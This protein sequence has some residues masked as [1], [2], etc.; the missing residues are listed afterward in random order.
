MG[1]KADCTFDV[2]LCTKSPL[3]V[4]GN[5]VLET[6]EACDGLML[7]GNDCKKLGFVGGKLGCKADC[8]LDSSACISAEACD[9]AIDDDK[10]GHI[11][12]SDLDCFG[13]MGCVSA[14]E[15]FCDD[16]LDNDK[17]GLVDCE[18]PDNC[19][20]LMMCAPGAGAV[21]S[22][23]ASPH[24][25]ASDTN[26]PVCL[27]ETQLDWTGG[28]CTAFCNPLISGGCPGDA[29]CVEAKPPLQWFGKGLCL[30]GCA[31]NADCR[32]G[33]NCVTPDGSL[34]AQK[35]CMPIH[36]DCSGGAD[37]DMDGLVD[38]LDPSCEM[39]AA[40]TEYCN[41]HIDD[42]GD[43]LVD[44][45]DMGCASSAA[46][47]EICDNGGD[48]NGNGLSD[49]QDPQCKLV[50]NC[51]VCGDGFVSGNEQC[52][53]PDGLGCGNDCLIR[54]ID[55][56]DLFD[57]DG[58]G[59]ADCV[60]GSNCQTAGLCVPGNG[61]VG[62]A[63]SEST[64]CS[65][66]NNDPH[67]FALPYFPEWSGGY[68][69]E[70]CNPDINDC[71]GD[72][73]CLPVFSFGIDGLC[74]DGCA[75]DADCRSGYECIYL[76]SGLVCYPKFEICNNGVDDNDNGLVD[77]LDPA[78]PPCE[79]CNNGIDDNYDGLIDCEDSFTCA[80]SDPSCPNPALCA[81][82][83]PLS[84]GVPYNG[85]TTGGSAVFAG[86]CTGFGQKAERIFGFTPGQAG[87]FGELQVVLASATDQGFYVRTDCNNFASEIGCADW[88]GGGTD[89]KLSLAVEGG[90]P[91]MIFVDGWP[92]GVDPAGPFTLTATFIVPVCGDGIVSIGEEC[93]PPDGTYCG[94]DCQIIQESQC[95]NLLDDDGDGLVDCEDPEDC[96]L[97]GQCIPGVGPTG[98]ACTVNNDCAA[99]GLDPVCIN[100]MEFPTWVGG[101]CSEFCDVKA[102]DCTLGAVCLD[103][104][105]SII[106]NGLCFDTCTVNADCRLGYQ[107]VDSGFG[108][109]I[110]FPQ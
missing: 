77:C 106:G 52:D 6:G 53:P 10:D 39:D 82:A 102:N 4:C 76:L 98:S 51:A 24:D 61:P 97:L 105:V 21:G 64:D 91:L 62:S 1:C 99:N 109:F 85:D 101:Y 47:S 92:G 22:P 7:G 84:D 69:S 34:G 33:Y 31:A 88:Y 13:K 83:I 110:C 74:M 58:D 5:G 75:A 78:C 20:T 32:P 29:I 17:D 11:D 60:D 90:I 30:D 94:A 80:Q 63:C 37:E 12:C 45:D 19:Q 42:D 67:C 8:M 27:T 18:D 2:S 70:Y 86:T 9:N 107:C 108:Q 23:C 68:C 66:D 104:G 16:F 49:C 96:H 57:N 38:C 93:D 15:V 56:R 36:E 44:C 65:A 79:I 35:V 50:P 40:C 14:Q 95:Q 43:G 72:A 48:D 103:V 3:V 41:N 81:A 89:E 59:L 100:E 28:T 87:Q 25:C 26:A 73:L 54:E 46:C 55:C 71:P